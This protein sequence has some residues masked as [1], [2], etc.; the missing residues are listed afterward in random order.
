MELETKMKTYLDNINEKFHL[1]KRILIESVSRAVDLKKNQTLNNFLIIPINFIPAL[2]DS[3]VALFL[4]NSYPLW[5]RIH[6][7]D[8]TDAIE[9]VGKIFPAIPSSL[10]AELSMYFKDPEIFTPEM[11]DTVWTALHQMCSDAIAYG[12]YSRKP[13][14]VAKSYTTI[15]APGVKLREGIELFQV[16]I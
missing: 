14:P 3:K 10:L 8:D 11:K 16:T 7:K 15:F 12:H 6:A 2:D 4:T 1:L 9:D 13:D 5:S